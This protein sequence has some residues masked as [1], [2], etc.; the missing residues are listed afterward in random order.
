MKE[1]GENLE[2]AFNRSG[3]RGAIQRVKER[4][5]RH[6]NVKDGLRMFEK[7]IWNHIIIL[8]SYV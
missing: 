4:G 3:E 2:G 6:Q 8:L 7:A 5:W 1:K